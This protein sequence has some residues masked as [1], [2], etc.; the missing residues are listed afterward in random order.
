MKIAPSMLS[1]DFSRLGEETEKVS[2]A[3]A[4]Y[5]HLDVMD[6]IFVKNITFGP[7][8]IKSIRKN[9]NLP[10]DVHLMISEPIRYIEEFVEAGADIITFHVEA[11]ERVLEAIN[12]IKTHKKLVGISIKPQ[13]PVTEILRYL[14]LIDLALI[15]TVEP[16]FGGQEFM[17]EMM[18]KVEIL[19]KEI[20][21]KKLKT[22]IEIDGGINKKTVQIAAKSGTDIC[23]AGTSIFKSTNI[24]EAIAELK[25]FK[26]R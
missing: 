23:V 10:F 18:E 15:M 25:N 22:L 26:F 3:G 2:K 14:G 24:E 21:A 11:E 7:T 9:T 13:T 6:G 20:H 5:I 8:V 17:S 12:L 19:K 1:S 4:D 16:G